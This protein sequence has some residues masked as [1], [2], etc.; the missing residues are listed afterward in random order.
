VST[1]VL[2]QRP[3]VIPFLYIPLQEDSF[4]ILIIWKRAKIASSIAFCPI[5]I[6]FE[7]RDSRSFSPGKSLRRFGRQVH[8]ACTNFVKK[9]QTDHKKKEWNQF[10]LENG[11]LIP[12]TLGYKSLF[13]GKWHNHHLII[14]TLL[15]GIMSS[16][17]AF[18]VTCCVRGFRRIPY[19]KNII[20]WACYFIQATV[21]STQ[22]YTTA[23]FTSTPCLC[24]SYDS[25]DKHRLFPKTILTGWPL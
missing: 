12:N 16:F 18:N 14:Y 21:V 2:G 25:D 22:A 6:Q 4:T 7:T 24:V 19:K 9:I 10:S 1:T 3:V 5:L 23:T 15:F 8:C 17:L 11:I 13:V 20:L